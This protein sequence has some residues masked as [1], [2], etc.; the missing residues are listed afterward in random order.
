MIKVRFF[1]G[2]LDGTRRFIH[3][4]DDGKPLPIYR[5]FV[6]KPEQSISVGPE[7]KEPD[8]VVDSYLLH[9]IRLN[10]RFSHYEYHHQG[11]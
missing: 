4:Q 7:H 8:E 6:L 5:Y 3:V 9:E 10:G 2:P 1:G 11:R